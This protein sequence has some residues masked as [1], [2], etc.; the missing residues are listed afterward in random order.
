MADWYAT[1]FSPGGFFTTKKAGCSAIWYATL[2]LAHSNLPASFTL[3][4]EAELRSA[5]EEGGIIRCKKQD[6]MTDEIKHH[7]SNDKLVTKLALN[8][9]DTLSFVL[10]DDLSIKR[11]KFSEELREQNDD[12]S[13]EDPAARIDADFA[14]V[15][16]ELS[17]FIPAL[18]A[19][20][21]GEEQA[22]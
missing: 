14:L 10:G 15:T 8:W 12:V 9:G 11:L 16:A 1:L 17:Q 2:L 3:E 18:F 4:D 7:L 6:L 19:A 5:M 21:G 22:Q 20:L 13:N